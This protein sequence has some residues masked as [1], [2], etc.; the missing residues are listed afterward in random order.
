MA[1]LSPKGFLRFASAIVGIMLF[2]VACL[3]FNTLNLSAYSVDSQAQL[4]CL[5]FLGVCFGML[6]TFAELKWELFFFF[7]G[8]MRYRLGRAC[9]FAVSGIM[10]AILGKSRDQQCDCN[11]S[12]ILIVEGVALM[13]LAILQTIAIFIFGNNSAPLST[14]EAMCLPP[15]AVMA[16]SISKEAAPFC[17][18]VQPISQ[19]SSPD[20]APE[21]HR[22][23]TLMS[24]LPE[25][26][27]AL[28]RYLD[29]I[30]SE[31]CSENAPYASQYRVIEIFQK[32]QAGNFS[33]AENAVVNAKLGALYL[34]VE[35]PHHAQKALED[36]GNFFFPD[37]VKYATEIT[38]DD[39]SQDV[40]AA[41][42]VPNVLKEMPKVYVSNEHYEFLVMIAELSNQ[43]GVLWS[44]R[45]RPLKA[46]CYLSAGHQLCNEYAKTQKNNSLVAAQTYAHFY[47]A[48]VYG[49]LEMADQSATFCLSTLEL[50][51]LQFVNDKSTVEWTG[52]SDWV[53][54]ALKLVDFYFETDNTR[55]AATCLMACEYL[56]LRQ[57]TV[58]EEEKV[59]EAEIYL[60]WSRVHGTTLRLAGLQKN[61]V[62]IDEVKNSLPRP[63]TMEA[64]L[65]TLS[66]TLDAPQDIV[67]MKYV[68][69]STVDTY[70][71]AR[72]VF[73]MGLRACT[74]AQQVFVLDGY[75]TQHVRLL[76]QESSLYRHL[77]P[78]EDDRRRRVAMQRRR[79]ALLSPLLGNTL[80]E[81]VFTDLL[82]ELY[83]ECA[84]I[85]SDIFELKQSKEST[86]K[87]MT[88]AIKAVQCYQQ[89]L[90]LYYPS[91]LPLGSSTQDP[92]RVAV[93]RG[94]ND[95]VLPPGGNL[96]PNEVRTFLLGYFGL[97]HICGKFLFPSNIAKTVG[98]WRQS[99]AYHKAVTELVSKYENKYQGTQ[100]KELRRL[101]QKEF[102]ISSEMAELLPEKIDQ[103]VYN[104]KAL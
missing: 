75:V 35:E 57:G 43:L 71:H 88:Y 69:A 87:A 104:G 21:A 103:L 58:D 9:I 29:D 2:V 38:S 28:L 95:V 92:V 8:F 56:L 13:V 98:Y 66:Q 79:L 48:Q 31:D 90:L 100:G 15:V 37:L 83:F 7:F 5:C 53:R 22:T 73:K 91:S 62:R 93:L 82:Q 36:A 63:S 102:E 96:S 55:D 97:A 40:L 30:A 99:L 17:A 11:D 78:F 32:L 59:L 47:L 68:P 45:S 14:K 10:T 34:L 70:E 89:F 33:P 86:E 4:G 42:M 24:H 20:S 27:H 39:G 23:S 6:L 1:I 16:P 61:G 50:Q 94:G 54:N 41:K 26:F 25:E 3:G 12:T 60:K 67:Y 65:N 84:E 72:D 64:T 46:L 81:R 52:A 77:L 19:V 44:S 101:F 49:N 85:Q 51:L 74:C 80:N 18:I 76:Q